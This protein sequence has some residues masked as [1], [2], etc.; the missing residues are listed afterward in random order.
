ME[1][2]V[3]ATSPALK[4]YLLSLSKDPAKVQAL[5]KN[6]QAEL[7]AAGLS[8]ADQEV[9]KSADPGRIRAAISGGQ[10]LAGDVTVVVVIAVF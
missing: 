4:S 5:R 6:P 2:T 10:A 1:A 8:A 3:A 9:I 7:Q